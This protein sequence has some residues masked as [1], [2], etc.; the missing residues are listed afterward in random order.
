ML[1][2][3]DAGGALAR[4]V[5][6]LGDRAAGHHL[7]AEAVVAALAGVGARLGRRERVLGLHR[8][9][10]I[11]ATTS[12]ATSRAARSAA[13]T[14]STV[15]GIPRSCRSSAA[16]HTSAICCQ[17]ISPSRNASTATSLAALSHAGAVPPARPAW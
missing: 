3:S 17:E 11:S 10:R 1:V 9:T 7:V 4:L 12:R 15:V 13:T 2:A 5:G 6:A 14:S 8:A 16:L